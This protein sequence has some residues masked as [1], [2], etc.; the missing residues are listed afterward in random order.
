MVSTQHVSDNVLL[1][2]YPFDGE[3]IVSECLK[4]SNDGRCVFGENSV[5]VLQRATVGENSK[6]ADSS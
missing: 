5:Y 3:A 1:A 2:F 6:M 4:L